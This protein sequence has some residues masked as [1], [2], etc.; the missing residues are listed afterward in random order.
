MPWLSNA[1]SG[2][3]PTAGTSDCY[4]ISPAGRRMR[5][6]AEVA[7]HEGVVLE[8]PPGDADAADAAGNAPA[9]EPAD[10]D[11]GAGSEGEHDEGAQEPDGDEGDALPR[12]DVA[13]GARKKARVALS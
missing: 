5:S 6:R 13:V 7:A 12:A 4:W 8:P 1:R 11:D 3:S 9:A 10:A 2:P